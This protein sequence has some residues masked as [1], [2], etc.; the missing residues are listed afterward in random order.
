M[1]MN[2]RMDYFVSFLIQNNLKPINT[3]GC[4]PVQI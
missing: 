1:N 2:K 3:D 4:K